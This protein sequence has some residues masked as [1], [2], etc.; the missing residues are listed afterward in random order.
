MWRRFLPVA[1]GDDENKK[2]AGRFHWP[3]LSPDSEVDAVRVEPNCPACSQKELM[4]KQKLIPTC[5]LTP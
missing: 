4:Q 1:T 3:P 5:K 2:L